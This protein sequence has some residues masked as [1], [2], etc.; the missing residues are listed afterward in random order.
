MLNDNN[1]K[2]PG[3][4]PYSDRLRTKFFSKIAKKNRKKLNQEYAQRI[5]E[6]D[7][8]IIASF[9]GA[10]TLYHDIG[11]KF[12][13]PT[14]NLAFDGPDFCRFCCNLDF[15]LSKELIE[16]KTDKVPYPVG[17]LGEDVEIRF[18]HYK[19]FE[20]AKKK[21]EERVLRI[22]KNKIIVMAQDR[23]GMGSDECIKM[24]DKI[25]YKKI[26]FTSKNLGYDWAVFCD[27]FKNRPCVG[28][29]TGISNFKGQ[30]YYEQ[31]INMVDFL[32]SL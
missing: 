20:E 15:Y 8:T 13:S 6:K 29:L 23:D 1:I 4:P 17:Q 24:F 12:M 16:V 19:T 26:M 7:F 5:N 31:N 21:W 18:V 11:M 10:G 22:N 32:N 27:Y 2:R 9:C 3:K 28:V 25:P 14:I 30:R